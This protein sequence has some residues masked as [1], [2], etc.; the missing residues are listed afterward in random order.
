MQSQ[1]IDDLTILIQTLIKN[2]EKSNQ[3][4]LL[5]KGINQNKM[6]QKPQEIQTH[7][8]TEQQQNSQR[9]TQQNSQQ[10]NQ[11]LHTTQQNSSNQQPVENNTNRANT[12]DQPAN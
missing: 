11:H 7:S 1:K 12:S 9:H 5:L 10:I 4:E 2:V 8:T 3:S 6:Q